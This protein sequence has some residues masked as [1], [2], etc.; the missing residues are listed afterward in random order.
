MN[1]FKIQWEKIH[2]QQEIREMSGR[3]LKHIL[4]ELRLEWKPDN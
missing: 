2:K 4:E 3:V 1:K